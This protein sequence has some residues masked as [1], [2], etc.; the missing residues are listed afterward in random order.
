M[1]LDRY[2]EDIGRR[3]E[4][5]AEA[6][7]AETRELAERLV[8]PLEAA[9]RLA[10]LDALSVA[11]EEITVELAP[12]KVELRL[13]GGEPS[14]VVEGIPSGREVEAAGPAVEAPEPDEGPT[15]RVNLRMADSLKV[16]VDAAA[17]QEG[18]SVNAWLVRAAS[19]ALASGDR[20]LG[21]ARQGRRGHQKVTGWVQ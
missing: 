13:R 7:G 12:A 21:A 18:R 3:F 15:S 10:L 20:G 9:V 5:A 17:A 4:V 19:A 1:H 6:G 2:V 8:L 16:R 11:A 14:F